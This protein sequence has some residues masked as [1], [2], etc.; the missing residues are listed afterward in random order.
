MQIL[1]LQEGLQKALED[2]KQALEDKKK[3]IEELNESRTEAAK[4]L[5]GLNVDRTEIATKLKV[6][7]TW[8]Q[9]VEQSL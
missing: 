8:L 5:L 1:R 4:L 9:K 3:T 2:K 6:S 7:G